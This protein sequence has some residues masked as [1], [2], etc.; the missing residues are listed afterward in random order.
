MSLSSAR[1]ECLLFRGLLHLLPPV[2]SPAVLLFLLPS[3]LMPYS[4][5]QCQ[6]P[7]RGVRDGIVAGDIQ[8]H[9]SLSRVNSVTSYSVIG[10][11]ALF[12]MGVAA[13]TVPFWDTVVVFPS[14]FWL[15]SSDQV[16][17]V[18]FGLR[19]TSVYIAGTGERFRWTLV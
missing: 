4:T 9:R 17:R 12:S 3:H 2:S 10:L 6:R 15:T 7:S 8:S 11:C 18:A 19:S 1:V 16:P 13:V 14:A 5:A